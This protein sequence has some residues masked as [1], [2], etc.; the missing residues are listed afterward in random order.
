MPQEYPVAAAKL[1]AAD[2]PLENHELMAK[3][4]QFELELSIPTG[5][6]D[7]QHEAQ[8]EIEKGEKHSAMLQRCCSEGESQ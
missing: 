8:Q 7:S 6:R 5:R 1:G 4:E 2:L 3:D